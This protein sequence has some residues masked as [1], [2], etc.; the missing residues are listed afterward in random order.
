MK[1]LKNFTLI[2]LLIVIAILAILAALLLPALQKAKQTAQSAFCKN[3]L[4]QM[5]V[6]A[7]GYV[8][9]NQDWLMPSNTL[10][11]HKAWFSLIQIYIPQ[12]AWKKSN[13]CPSDETPQTNGSY[14]YS[15][16]LGC[17]MLANSPAYGNYY[18][19]S[20]HLLLPSKAIQIADGKTQDGMII[21]G[22][23]QYSPITNEY[24]QLNF[25]AGAHNIWH[26]HGNNRANLLFIAG[27]V[28]SEQH[29]MTEWM[30][31][32]PQRKLWFRGTTKY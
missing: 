30:C 5:S 8:N 18:K 3:N 4:R 29:G 6:G 32:I 17:W 15:R 22:G 13:K 25:P 21:L 7:H 23:I 9:D 19:K 26:R 28:A 11:D 24:M 20:S 1:R 10:E 16:S 12:K 31:T 27:N 2:E 14:G